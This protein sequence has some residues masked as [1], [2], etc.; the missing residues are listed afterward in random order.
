MISECPRVTTREVD[1]SDLSSFVKAHFPFDDNTYDVDNFGQLS[2]GNF[3]DVMDYDQM[4]GDQNKL[5]GDVL[6]ADS[7][8]SNMDEFFYQKTGYERL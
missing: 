8:W 5:T 3:N 6:L 4:S 7:L 1:D 2:T